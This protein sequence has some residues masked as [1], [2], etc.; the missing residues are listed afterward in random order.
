VPRALT[1]AQRQEV[2]AE[3]QQ[4]HA[5]FY[6]QQ[7]NAKQRARAEIDRARAAEKAAQAALDTLERQQE[8]DA[9]AKRA[10]L[11]RR[12]TGALNAVTAARHNAL[13]RQA[14]LAPMRKLSLISY[15]TAIVKVAA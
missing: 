8:A 7:E 12:I 2:A 14:E 9:T 15:T 11:E 6:R 10:N 5:G 13:N 4:L 1:P 3:I